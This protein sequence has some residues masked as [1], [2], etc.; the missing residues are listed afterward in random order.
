MT[1]DQALKL[2]EKLIADKIK[3]GNEAIFEA[4]RGPDGRIDQMKL[5]VACAIAT[6]KLADEMMEKKQ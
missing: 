2:A 6:Y 3:S 4:A 1:Y 5:A